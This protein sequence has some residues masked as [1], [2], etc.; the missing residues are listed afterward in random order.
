M[1]PTVMAIDPGFGNTKVCI[2]GRVS[3][4]QS[5]V[6]HPREV[7][8]ATLGV[9]TQAEARTVKFDDHT[10]GVGEY[11]WLWGSPRGSM[12]YTAIAAPERQALM[13]SALSELLP[14]EAC[15]EEVALVVGLPVPLLMETEQAAH[16][17]DN[18]KRLKRTHTFEVS[19][20]RYAMTITQIKAVAQPVGAYMDW[21]YTSDL[22]P[23][24]GGAQ[25]EVAVVDIGMNTLDLY[26]LQG[27]Q[28]IPRYI[29]GEKV[30]VRRLLEILRVNGHDLEEKD[31][32]LR[33]GRL[34]PTSGDLE[35]WLG[36]IMATIERTWPSLKRFS[37]V[38]P[39]GGG[40]VVLG[41]RL[42]M[43]LLSKGAVVHWPDEPI[44]TNVRG[45]WKLGARNAG[46]R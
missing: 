15:L 31:A 1:T 45:L 24:A 8:L 12:D 37:T 46:S 16:V 35:L 27:G 38:I 34:K 21:L 23:R 44:I 11:A 42:K 30:G 20:H 7:G 9:R 43:T 25:A 2:D 17:K 14:L 33:A 36:E 40:A 4:V 5:A 13:Y 3:M 26:V 28:A 32:A 41:D 19:R 39:A 29:G 10:F 6:A 22:A 18:L